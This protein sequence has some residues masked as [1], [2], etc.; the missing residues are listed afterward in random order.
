MLCLLAPLAFG[1]ARVD[2]EKPAP[3]PPVERVL[4]PREKV[5]KVASAE[6][7]V[8]EKTGRN[9]GEVDKY[10][11]AV[12]LGGSRAPYCAAFVHWVGMQALGDANPYPRTA[13]SPSMVAGGRRVTGDFRPL[14]GEAFGIWFSSKNRVAHTGIV[15][16]REGASLVT[17][18]GNTSGD[19]AA[20][21]AADRE[22]GGVY[23]KR[24]HLRTIYNAR[25]WLAR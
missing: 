12:G 21:S 25:D 14:G 9:D 24:R 5:L 20:G 16:K 23:R 17:I 19:A 18:E 4:T 1:G 22:G 13:W 6:V 3:P 7:G 11:R 15:E 2:A 8:R 10:L